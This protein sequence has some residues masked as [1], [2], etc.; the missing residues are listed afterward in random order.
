[1]R[2]HKKEDVDFIDWT[3]SDLSD[4]AKVNRC[5]VAAFAK[6]RASLSISGLA[7]LLEWVGSNQLNY[8]IS[9]P[10]YPNISMALRRNGR[11]DLGGHLISNYSYSRRPL[12]CL[13]YR[14]GGAAV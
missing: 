1:M 8:N 2:G 7:Y 5:S 13:H 14:F 10:T 4:V 9:R 12:L 11:F 6:P 3:G